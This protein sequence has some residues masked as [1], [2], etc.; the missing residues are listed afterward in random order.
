[1]GELEVRLR[2]KG[3]LKYYL[4]VTRDNQ[5]A[6]AF[7]QQIGCEVMDILILGKVIK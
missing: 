6:V 2:R 1:M 5:D 7:Y 4:L 3:C